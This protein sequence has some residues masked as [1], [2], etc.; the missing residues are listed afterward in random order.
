LALI[1]LLTYATLQAVKTKPS[2]ATTRQAGVE[3]PL[4]RDA[5][6][7]RQAASPPDLASS[8][9]SRIVTRVARDPQAPDAGGLVALN[10]RGYNYS[11][12]RLPADLSSLRAEARSSR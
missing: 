4:G 2:E 12:R 1:A 11:V 7:C 9:L 8:Q 5:P 3:A 10:G 6:V